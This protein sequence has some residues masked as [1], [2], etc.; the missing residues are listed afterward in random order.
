[1]KTIASWLSKPVF[2]RENLQTAREKEVAMKHQERARKRR[3]FDHLWN[4]AHEG[5]LITL[6]HMLDNPR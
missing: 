4:C 3:I 1:M 5:D 6:M 2:F